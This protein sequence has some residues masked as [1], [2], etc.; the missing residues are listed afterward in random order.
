MVFYQ[1]GLQDCYENYREVDRIKQEESELGVES[2]DAAGPLHRG[3]ILLV[4]GGTAIGNERAP[5][6]DG[7]TIMARHQEFDM[8]CN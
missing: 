1:Y 4:T 3:A 6:R 5:T 7:H 2:D 8:F